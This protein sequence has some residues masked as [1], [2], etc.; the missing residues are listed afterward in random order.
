VRRFALKTDPM[1][2]DP[3]RWGHSLGNLA[4]IW[5]AALDAAGA[6]SV[7]EVG[8]YAGDTTRILLDWAEA[9]GAR[10]VAVDPDPQPSLDELARRRPALELIR[11]TSLDALGTLGPCDAVILDG[12]HNYYTVTHELRLLEERGEHLPLVICHD[13]CW[14]HGRR[15]AYYAIEQIPEEWRQPSVELGH[16]FPGDPGIHSAG[17][18]FY[19]HRLAEREGG[20]ANGVLTAVEDFLRARPGL[21]L[22]V[23]PAFFGLAVMWPAGAAYAAD[24]AA[25][26]EPYRDHPVLARLEANRVLNLA[27]WEAD[28][29]RAEGE[30]HDRQWLEEH[31]R[32]GSDLLGRLLASRTF[33][34]AVWLSRLYRR[35]APAVSKDEIR[36]VFER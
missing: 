36:R 9:A 2:N 8:A 29:A 32:A 6:R 17:L 1:E 27:R 22:A 18:L 31:W 11:A 30:H 10:V 26:L 25:V 28:R 24:L 19:H 16:L 4:E 7:V 23:V 35:G 20:P 21:R 33:T 14:P 15:D 13:V 5:L 34:V 3:G 12:D